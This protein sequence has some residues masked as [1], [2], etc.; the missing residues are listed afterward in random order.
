MVKVDL[1]GVHAVRA[2]LA[3]GK[4]AVYHYAWR[5]GPRLEG[6]PGSPTFVASYN[7]A[8]ASRKVVPEGTLHA[9]VAAYR[10]SGEF[11][12]RAESSKRAYRA[13]L[14]LI[15]AEFG[16]MPLKAVQDP[17][18]R[19]EFKAWRDSMSATP[20]KA[21]YAWAVLARVLEHFRFNPDRI[22]LGRRSG[23]TRRA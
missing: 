10:Q 3:S 12:G 18:A 23:R 8:H 7:T 21:D 5:G 4:T 16:D 2:K 19:G 15:E 20:R 9:L 6:K 13:Y 14:A 1:R 22:R 11:K 17:R